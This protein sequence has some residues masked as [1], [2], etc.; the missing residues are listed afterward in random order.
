MADQKC[1]LDAIAQVR[2]PNGDHNRMSLAN[3]SSQIR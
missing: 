3:R 1:E 2:P